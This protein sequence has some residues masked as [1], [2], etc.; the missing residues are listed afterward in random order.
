MLVYFIMRCLFNVAAPVA[1]AVAI[2]SALDPLQ[3]YYERNIL[4]DNVAALF[5][6]LYM[7]CAILVMKRP[8]LHRILLLQLVSALVISMRMSLLPA[9]LITTVTLPI[10]LLFKE[11]GVFR[12]A[13]EA[14]DEIPSSSKLPSKRAFL[15]SGWAF[16]LLIFFFGLFHSWYKQLNGHL[17]NRHNAYHYHDGYFLLALLSPILKPEDAPEPRLARI[18]ESLQDRFSYDNRNNQMYSRRGLVNEV[19]KLS[20][21]RELTN[22]LAK[23]TAINA[24]KR[25]PLGVLGIELATYRKFFDSNPAA[26]ITG[27]LNLKTRQPLPQSFCDTLASEF[28]LSVSP[29]WPEQST[30]TKVHLIRNA[31]WIY[32]PL[33]SPLWGVALVLVGRRRLLVPS[34]FLLILALTLL[35]SHLIGTATVRYLLTPSFLNYLILGLLL[36]EITSRFASGLREGIRKCL[37]LGSI[38]LMALW[39]SGSVL[40]YLT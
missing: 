10:A 32:M 25:D 34:V 40:R 19:K 11:I 24:I 38:A 37:F 22:R 16:I 35:A 15:K 28:N 23:K 3:L 31:W 7:T 27:G 8:S 29:N 4:T 36:N 6:A 1:I 13:R 14:S 18:I 2:L 26:L 17:S 39:L 21:N 33:L 20:K 30:P 9:T 12:D 5:F